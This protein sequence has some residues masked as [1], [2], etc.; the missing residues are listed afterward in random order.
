MFRGSTALSIV[1]V[2]GTGFALIKWATGDDL[3]AVTFFA[4]V[5][6]A[7]LA[8]AVDDLRKDVDRLKKRLDRLAAREDAPPF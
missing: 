1:I 2:V 8:G 6:T 5:S 4:A 7:F 3:T